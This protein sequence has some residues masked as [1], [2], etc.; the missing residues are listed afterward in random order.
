MPGF[1]M[2]SG[3]ALTVL[4]EWVR[5]RSSGFLR[6]GLTPKDFEDDSESSLIDCRRMAASRFFIGG[7]PNPARFVVLSSTGS[8][9][10]FH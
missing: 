9:P 4:K 10:R 8:D 5:P 2:P 3:A 6:W 7:D 1:L